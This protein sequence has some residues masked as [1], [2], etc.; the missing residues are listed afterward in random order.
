MKKILFRSIFAFSIVLNVAGLGSLAWHDWSHRHKETVT[1][2]GESTLSRDDLKKIKTL[3]SSNETGN[4]SEKRR[5]MQLKRLELLD[6]IEKEPNDNE[7]LHKTVDELIAV[8]ADKER[9]SVERLRKAVNALPTDKRTAFLE[10]L[11]NRVG[12]GHGIGLE[13]GRKGSEKP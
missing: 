4:L 13:H 9:V 2:L 3:Y 11:K 8:M 12:K 10:Y 7:R 1:S 5:Q 6:V